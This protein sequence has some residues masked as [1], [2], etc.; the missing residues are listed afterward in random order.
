MVSPTREQ[1][2][3]RGCTITVREDHTCPSHPWDGEWTVNEV[4][5]DMRFLLDRKP[6]P[7]G[8]TT[9]TKQH[10]I[11]ML[12]EAVD[13]HLNDKQRILNRAR[14]YWYERGYDQG[15]T[16]TIIE[17]QDEIE[18]LVLAAWEANAITEEKANE[19][20]KKFYLEWP[21]D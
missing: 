19:I 21:D 20:A 16:Q 6:H 13:A 1:V 12:R 2:T 7:L 14:K 3:Y 5:Y 17:M 10:C 11:Q 8:T 18:N 9:T 4:T 15:S